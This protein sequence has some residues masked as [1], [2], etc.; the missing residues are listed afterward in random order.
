MASI[1][2]AAIARKNT[3]LVI[4]IDRKTNR[5]IAL[6]RNT[7]PMSGRKAAQKSEVIPQTLNSHE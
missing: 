1:A 4:H 7:I 6:R 5:D 2:C 3:S